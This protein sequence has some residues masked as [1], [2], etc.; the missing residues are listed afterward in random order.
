MGSFI[1]FKPYVVI[2]SESEAPM[3]E[4]NRTDSL[5]QAFIAQCATPSARGKPSAALEK[6]IIRLQK[7]FKALDSKIFNDTGEKINSSWLFRF[8]ADQRQSFFVSNGIILENMFDEATFHSS[9][10]HQLSVSIPFHDRQGQEQSLEFRG[11]KRF[12][13]RDTQ[14]GKVFETFH[15]V[16]KHR[17]KDGEK[18][19]T[20]NYPVL[21]VDKAICHALK[22]FPE[23]MTDGKPNVLRSLVSLYTLADHDY[24]HSLAL[25]WREPVPKE[26]NEW[27]NKLLGGKPLFSS[28]YERNPHYDRPANYEVLSQRLSYELLNESEVNTARQVLN[29]GLDDITAFKQASH[30]R[31]QMPSHELDTMCAHLVQNMARFASHILPIQQVADVLHAHGYNYEPSEFAEVV[32]LADAIPQG[33]K[34]KKVAYTITA[35]DLVSEMP[36]VATPSKRHPQKPWRSSDFLLEAYQAAMAMAERIHYPP[37]QPPQLLRS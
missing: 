12:G 23:L 33:Y 31:Q 26:F 10:G 1:R 36:E 27:N 19:M 21:I 22:A 9:T 20:A 15:T 28:L 17:E 6:E 24:V 16:Y 34:T 35:N 30:K 29:A 13:T 5:A 8:M 37:S 2:S 11:I 3:A 4:R 32:Q 25:P 7:L 18:E 14:S